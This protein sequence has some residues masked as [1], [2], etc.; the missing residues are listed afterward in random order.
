MNLARRM[1]NLS[2]EPYSGPEVKV[3]NGPKLNRNFDV[4]EEDEAKD[5]VSE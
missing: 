3:D 2:V 5:Q 4:K 1:K